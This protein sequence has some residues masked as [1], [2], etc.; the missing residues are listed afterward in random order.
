M[1]AALAAIL[2]SGQAPSTWK[3][4][5]VDSGLTLRAWS[6]VG[7]GA[8]VPNR[9]PARPP[10]LTRK[11]ARISFPEHEAWPG[12]DLLV[13]A[14]G[15]LFVPQDGNYEFRITSRDPAAL[16]IERRKVAET[17][18]GQDAPNVEGRAEL[19]KGFVLLDLRCL[20]DSTS[21]VMRL[22]WRPP[23]RELLSLLPAESV[24]DI[25]RPVR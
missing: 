5:P 21:P 19:R 16:W 2:I 23:G 12:Q 11:I 25:R 7:P 14:S 24:F 20:A 3:G 10:I 18:G 13:V 15:F 4:L 6:L 9:L 17:F 22:D 1:T 8:S